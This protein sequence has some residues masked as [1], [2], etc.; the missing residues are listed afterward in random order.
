MESHKP[1]L[2]G[3]RAR[4]RQLRK[5]LTGPEKNLWAAIRSRKLA[6]LK[7]RRQFPIDRYIVDFYCHEHRLVVELDGDS[8][9]DVSEYDQL[10]Q[11]TIED[12]GFRVIRFD[13][14][15][16]LNDLDDVLAM[17]LAACGLEM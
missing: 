3:A 13:N 6:N 4:S 17:I 9:N 11:S 15:E 16:V 5:N 8:H 12:Q 10:R 14:D 2:L 1:E 7:F